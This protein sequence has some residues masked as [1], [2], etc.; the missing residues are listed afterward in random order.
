M[1]FMNFFHKY[2][3]LMDRHELCVTEI[4]IVYLC[5]RYERSLAFVEADTPL[6]NGVPYNYEAYFKVLYNAGHQ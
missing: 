5:Q 2:M 6:V 3:T 4:C 1:N